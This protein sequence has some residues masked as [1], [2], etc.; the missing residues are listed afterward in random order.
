MLNIGI[1]GFGRIG[2]VISRIIE[3][4]Y[5][6]NLVVVNDINPDIENIN[7][8]LNYDTNYG[9]LDNPSIVKQNSIKSKKF[10]F[11]VFHEAN[12][13][14]VPWAKNNVDLIIDSSGISENLNLYS[15]MKNE[16]KKIIVT[17]SPNENLVDKTIVFGVNHN[18]IDDKRDFVLSSS[19]CDAT[20]LTPILKLIND[21]FS[22]EKGFLTTLHPWLGYQNLLD[23]P[24]KSYAVPGEIVDNY[25]LGRSSP[26][27]MIPKNTSAISATYKVLPELRDKFESFSYRVPTNIVSS[28]DIVLSVKNNISNQIIKDLL[29]LFEK[30]NKSILG[31]NNEALVSTDFLG[32]SVSVTVDHRFIRISE[33]FIKMMC[34]YD[35]E[36]GYSSRV[37]DLASYIDKISE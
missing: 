1:N 21:N 13:L 8:L 20:A 31:N 18:L 11:K 29:Y 22:I 14:D 23:G 3:N 17:N 9:R 36:W 10:N 30:E 5:D 25:A 7:Y 4:R 27:T 37:C 34:W 15:K 32:S 6:L 2:R 16:V 35:N 24:S 19:I 26:M 12:L 33:N 28:S